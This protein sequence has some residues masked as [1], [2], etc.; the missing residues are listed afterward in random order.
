MML[1]PMRGFGYRSRMVGI[2]EPHKIIRIMKKHPQKYGRVKKAWDT[3]RIVDK[4][5]VDHL[6]TYRYLLTKEHM[7]GIN[8]K[9]KHAFNLE[10]SDL[11]EIDQARMQALVRKYG[12]H[13]RDT[14]GKAVQAAVLCERTINMMNHC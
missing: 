8:D 2:N 4:H 11:K 14:G 10:N 12:K 1:N 9:V 3:E 7:E 6:K 5:E 13:Y